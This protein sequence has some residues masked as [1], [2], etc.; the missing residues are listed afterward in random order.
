M[1]F[2]HGNPALHPSRR[3]GTCHNQLTCIRCCGKAVSQTLK[4]LVP[5]KILTRNLMVLNQ[6]RY[7]HHNLLA[8]STKLFLLKQIYPVCWTVAVFFLI[9][10]Q[11]VS[12][13]CKFMNYKPKSLASVSVVRLQICDHSTAYAKSV[14]TNSGVAVTATLETDEGRS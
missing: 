13:A 14:T 11:P 12:H 4:F 6:V 10:V 9:S 1:L 3:M 7:S 8:S 5:C 2:A